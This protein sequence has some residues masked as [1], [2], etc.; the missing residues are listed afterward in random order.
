MSQKIGNSFFKA[1][2]K[3][4]LA[5]TGF[6]MFSEFDLIE[7]KFFVYFLVDKNRLGLHIHYYLAKFLLNHSLYEIPYKD[8]D[9]LF[10][11]L[12]SKNDY[13]HQE[14]STVSKTFF[15]NKLST[16]NVLGQMLPDFTSYS[17]F[18][19]IFFSVLLNSQ[20]PL[21][22]DDRDKTYFL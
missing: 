13:Y 8:F 10:F 5:N 7:N 17:Y 18:F 11:H 9:D 6:Y 3:D 22:E 2:D 16:L 15:K 12:L 1:V 4:S 19:E 20:S 14:L 21:L